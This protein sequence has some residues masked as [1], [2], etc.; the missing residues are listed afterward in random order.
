MSNTSIRA[1][2]QAH[3]VP[4]ISLCQ[5]L[6]TFPNLCTTF[7]TNQSRSDNNNH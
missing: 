5:F 3:G 7:D 6:V 2:T 4:A 1:P